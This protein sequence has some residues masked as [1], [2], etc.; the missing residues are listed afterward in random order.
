MSEFLLNIV[1]IVISLRLICVLWKLINV[2]Y[3]YGIFLGYEVRFV[4]DDWLILMWISKRLGLEIYYILLDELVFNIWY[5][6]V[7]CVRIFKGCGKEYFD[8]V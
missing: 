5:W 3:V 8:F 6:V 7:I 1:I 2:V 4:K